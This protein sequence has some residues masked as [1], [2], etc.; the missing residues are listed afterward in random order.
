MHT[1]C[2]VLFV[3]STQHSFLHHTDRGII[4]LARILRKTET[5]KLKK[6][7]QITGDGLKSIASRSIKYVNLNQSTGICDTGIISLVNNCPNIERLS[8]CELHKVSDV[9]LTHV[10]VALKDK[11]VR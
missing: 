3:H 4:S 11:L 2:N 10:A 6:L 8:V 7:R 9:S 1:C 5:L